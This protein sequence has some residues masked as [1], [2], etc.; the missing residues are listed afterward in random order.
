MATNCHL[1][2]PSL[3]RMELKFSIRNRGMDTDAYQDQ[4][5]VGK[6]VTRN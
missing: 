2:L 5:E 3:V 6:A 1:I 4:S